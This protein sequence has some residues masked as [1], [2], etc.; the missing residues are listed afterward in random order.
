MFNQSAVDYTKEL[1]RLKTAIEKAKT[2]RAKAEANK[3][4][5]EKRLEELLNECRALGVAPEQLETEIEQLDEAIRT[6]LARAK[7]MIPAEYLA[8]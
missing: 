3:E 7:E 6:G 2:E 4:S 1:N 8:G 5:L